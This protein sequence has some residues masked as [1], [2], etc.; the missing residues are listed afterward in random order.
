M[1]IVAR[2]LFTPCEFIKISLETAGAVFE[3]RTFMV[4]AKKSPFALFRFFE[5]YSYSKNLKV[6]FKE[7]KCT[8]LTELER[9]LK[10]VNQQ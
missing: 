5:I 8:Y 1:V 3:S 10:Q 6:T 4:L 9:K 2:L 7:E